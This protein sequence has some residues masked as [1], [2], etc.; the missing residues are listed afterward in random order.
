[1]ASMPAVPAIC[2]NCGA[3]FGSG[4]WMEGGSAH[5]VGNKSGPCPN[6]GAMGSI[7]DGFY[8][9]IGQTLR[10]VSD[11][12]PER[13][14]HLR[15][16]DRVCSK[17]R[18]PT[19]RSRGD[20]RKRSGPSCPCENAPHSTRRWSVL[21]VHSCSGGHHR[22]AHQQ[23]HGQRADSYREGDHA[24]NPASAPGCAHEEAAPAA[25]ACEG[26]PIQPQGEATQTQVIRASLAKKPGEFRQTLCR[27]SGSGVGV[28]WERRVRSCWRSCSRW[29]AARARAAQ[30]MSRR[31]AGSDFVPMFLTGRA[32]PV[33]TG[34]R[35]RAPTDDRAR[36]LS[37]PRPLAPRA[38]RR[39]HPPRRP[40]PRHPL[41]RLQRQR[42]FAS[43]RGG[44]PKVDGS[45][46][47]AGV[48]PH[49]LPRTSGGPSAAHSESEK[50]RQSRAF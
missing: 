32:A 11:W 50:P 31:T 29:R 1:M 33:A 42:R 28:A 38:P 25:S 26:Q 3:V 17:G 36:R 4:N 15:S 13:R 46:L 5:M 45:E 27:P 24:A 19:S 22:S 49:Q 7:P 37:R 35:R 30:S 2:D 16:G 43:S 9:F 48:L 6:C 12:S 44:A 23:S 21:G 39:A 20:H 41:T 40:R 14:Q 18:R 10:I 8:E 34:A 47:V